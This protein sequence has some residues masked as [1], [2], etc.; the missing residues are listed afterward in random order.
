[1]LLAT[2]QLGGSNPFA[3]T[4]SVDQLSMVVGSVAGL[5][6]YMWTSRIE[7]L[8]LI[9]PTPP[10]SSGYG[11]FVRLFRIEPSQLYVINS[12][13]CIF[14]SIPA[15]YSD[16]A[17]TNAGPFD[18][19]IDSYADIRNTHRKPG[20]CSVLALL[21]VTSVSLALCATCFTRAA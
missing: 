21:L 14:R 17:A 6:R 12:W 5:G 4:L 20:W 16:F 11:S 9:A 3:L 15:R 2:L 8:S 10:P 18:N 13:H 1:M 7:S 19:V